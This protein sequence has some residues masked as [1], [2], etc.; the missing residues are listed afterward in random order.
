MGRMGGPRSGCGAEYHE[1]VAW[2]IVMVVPAWNTVQMNPD[3]I[4]A[5]VEF[6]FPLSSFSPLSHQST[7]Q[8]ISQPIYRPIN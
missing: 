2:A 7:N 4:M 1:M 8:Q 6:S 5:S 3:T